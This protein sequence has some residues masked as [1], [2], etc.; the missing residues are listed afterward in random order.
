M[1]FFLLLLLLFA[2]VKTDSGSIDQ[3]FENRLTACFSSI[4]NNEIFNFYCESGCQ[5][6]FTS[7]WYRIRSSV[8]TT[9]TTPDRNSATGSLEMWCM[10]QVTKHSNK[11]F[12]INV[13]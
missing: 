6:G 8:V 12:E 1:F 3:C 2:S 7:F 4:D 13:I 9:E 5:S 11:Y 10:M